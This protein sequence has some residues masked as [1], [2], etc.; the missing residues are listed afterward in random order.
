M[1]EWTRRVR[2]QTGLGAPSAIGWLLIA[3][4]AGFGCARQAPAPPQRAATNRPAS[5]QVRQRSTF[6]PPHRETVKT[7][8]LVTAVVPVTP[9]RPAPRP[10]V[11]RFG[12]AIYSVS[13]TPTIARAGDT[14]V[15]N[16]RTSSD[17]STVTASVTGFA[18][19]LQRRGPG[20]F[21][22]AFELPAAMPP[23]FHGTYRV[24][25]EAR[26]AVGAKATSH[27]SLQVQ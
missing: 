3:S 10:L 24:A 19:P 14:I 11:A 13:A 22:A 7:S 12:P 16:V 17:V 18:I 2:R 15:W 6:Q 1:Q 20:R 23:I 21:E 25:I 26:N 9:V 27:I 8:R 4:L 5:P